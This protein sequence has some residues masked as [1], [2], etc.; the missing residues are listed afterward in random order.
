MTEFKRI[1]IAAG[2]LIDD[3][4]VMILCGGAQNFLVKIHIEVRILQTFTGRNQADILWFVA[5]ALVKIAKIG[6]N[7]KNFLA[8]FFLDV[9]HIAERE[10][11]RV[12]RNAGLLGDL[13]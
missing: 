5:D 13:F 9:W 3:G 10:G 4:C 8:C 7:L 12:D 2:D 11:N 1:N 6:C